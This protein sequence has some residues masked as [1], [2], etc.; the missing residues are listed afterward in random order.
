MLSSNYDGEEIRLLTSVKK[1]PFDILYFEESLYWTS[2]KDKTVFKTDLK[3]AETS[4]YF[5]AKDEI[6]SLALAGSTQNSK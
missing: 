4:L 6:Y 5:Q 1:L 2:P 3:S